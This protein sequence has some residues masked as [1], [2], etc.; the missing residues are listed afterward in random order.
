M[1]RPTPSSTLLENTLLEDT[2]YFNTLN[3]VLKHGPVAEGMRGESGLFCPRNWALKLGIIR[4]SP[5]ILD[6]PLQPHTYSL[7]L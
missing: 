2:H 6:E 4:F 5:I 3:M 7:L 1:D